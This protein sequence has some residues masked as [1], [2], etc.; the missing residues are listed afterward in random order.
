M[1][2]EKLT[3]TESEKHFEIARARLIAASNDQKDPVS[4][5]LYVALHNYFTAVLAVEVEIV[6]GL[7]DLLERVDR[8]EKRQGPTPITTLR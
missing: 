5:N 7:N 4:Q 2:V 3:T 8:I 6:K 1:A